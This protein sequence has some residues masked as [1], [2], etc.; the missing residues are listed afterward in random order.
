MEERGIPSGWSYNPSSW[1][2]RLPIAGLA[3]LGFVIAT[4][5][6]LF[7]YQVFSSVWDPFFGSGTR[8]VLSSPLS[9]RIE[10]TLFVK[11]AALGAFGY[12]VDAVAGLV[13]GTKRWRT[14]PW[15]VLIFGLAVG[16]LG[17][18]SVLLVIAQPVVVG[19]WCTLCMTTAAIS[20]AMIG[21]AMDE[22]LASLQY[23]KGETS[24]GRSFWRVFWGLSESESSADAA[25]T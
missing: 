17:L 23:L 22:V 7:Q 21:P 3:L 1:S 15:I 2:Q 8:K 19:H 24:R 12:V 6:S 14:M 4:Y 20:I 11:D 5:L 18:V 13:G 25:K 16:P 10:S 9:K